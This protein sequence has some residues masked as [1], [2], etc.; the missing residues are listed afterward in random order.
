MT[1]TLYLVMVGTVRPIDDLYFILSHDGIFEAYRFPLL[2]TYS[3]DG[4]F[5]AYGHGFQ[6]IIH[7]PG[8]PTVLVIYRPKVFVECHLQATNHNI[9]TIL[10]ITIHHLYYKTGFTFSGNP[11]FNMGAQ[12]RLYF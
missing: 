6:D 3:H 1:F 11:H 12:W 7:G 2:Y 9:V 8:E 4:I 5:E 10:S